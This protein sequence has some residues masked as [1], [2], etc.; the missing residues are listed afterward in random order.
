RAR[1]CE[2]GRLT[3]IAD[4]SSRRVRFRIL[5]FITFEGMEGGGKST[6]ARLLVEYLRER[7]GAEAVVLTRE[8]GGTKIG[9]QIREVVHSQRNREMDRVT[10]F[11]LY[12]AARAQIVAEV[13]RPALTAGKL[14]VSDRF[15]DSTIAYQGYG[16][17]LDL[18]LVRRV[19]EL[20][21]G[22]LKPDLTFYLEVS[23]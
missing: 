20:A 11:L 9:E 17:Q 21:T 14:V 6:Q 13:I 3:G 18:D 8:P 2:R 10:E 16:R 15:A 22:G 5:M 12:N 4:G 23:I 1:V 19:I 7:L